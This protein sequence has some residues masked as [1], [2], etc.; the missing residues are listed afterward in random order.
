MAGQILTALCL[1]MVIE[2]LLPALD[3]ARFRKMV[4]LLAEVDDR[5]IRVIGLSSMVVGALLL[6]LL[7]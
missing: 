5:T 2:G 4:E 1:V 7:N 6:A 3:P